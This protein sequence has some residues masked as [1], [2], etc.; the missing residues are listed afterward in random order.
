M[1]CGQQS[2]CAVR[3][4]GVNFIV[5]DRASVAAMIMDNVP[6]VTSLVTTKQTGTTQ[7]TTD[8]RTPN[9]PTYIRLHNRNPNLT[10]TIIFIKCESEFCHPWRRYS[11]SVIH[12]MRMQIV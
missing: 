3:P 7:T 2:D 5:C 4:V 8:N 6:P 10:P 1:N 9:L 11:T 12:D